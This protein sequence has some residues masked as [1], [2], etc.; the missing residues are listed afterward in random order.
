MDLS[1]S[2]HAF[3]T[4]FSA[5]A[6][7]RLYSCVFSRTRKFC[8]PQKSISTHISPETCTTKNDPNLGP[9]R[10]KLVGMVGF[11]TTPFFTPKIVPKGGDDGLEASRRGE[12]GFQP[13][14]VLQR[15]E[16]AR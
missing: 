12:A 16:R 7:N 13:Q 5:D 10:A 14:A 9:Q 6:T 8:A 11:S 1:I 2:H 4:I 3:F 15:M